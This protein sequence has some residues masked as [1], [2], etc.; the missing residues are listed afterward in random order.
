VRIDKNLNL[1]VTLERETGPVHVH[2]TPLPLEIF[3]KYFLTISKAF[4][5]I[6]AEGL[7]VVA[8]PR[9]AGMMLEKIGRD[10]GQWDAI[11]GE[12]PGLLAH[13]RRLSFVIVPESHGWVQVP[14][15]EAINRDI[16]D[17]EDVSEVE[18]V[19]A[20]FICAYAMHHR[21]VRRQVLEVAAAHWSGR[22]TSSNS[23]DFMH[24]LPTSTGDESSG[25][26]GASSVPR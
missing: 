8:G 24:S 14:L 26:K 25:A 13:I 2:S 5:S 20:F 3:K 18:G 22:L 11:P 9:V 6:Y 21:N 10:L 7:T 4:A 17:E 23:T 15:H 16:L 19:I 12:D 1:V